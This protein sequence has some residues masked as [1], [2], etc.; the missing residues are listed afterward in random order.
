M[1]DPVVLRLWLSGPLQSWGTASR[2]D[3][4]ATERAPSKSAVIGLLAAALG[5]PRS[6]EVDDLAA[7][8]FGVCLERPGATLRDFHTV[9]AGT[10]PV[11]V[12]SGGTGRGIVTERYYLEDAAFTVGLEGDDERFMLELLDAAVQPRWLLALGRRSCPPAGPIADGRAI[13]RGRLEDALADGWRPEG[14]PSV[15]ARTGPVELLVEDPDGPIILSDQ[16]TGA[17]FERRTF[18]SRRVRSMVVGEVAA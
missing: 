8:R 9:G 1:A 13:F 17:A 10:D 15:Y 11:A 12:A 18:V 6:A 5:R 16:P 14:V 4:R 3:V 7:L 2:F